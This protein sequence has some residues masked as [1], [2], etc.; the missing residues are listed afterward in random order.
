MSLGGVT[1][2]QVFGFGLCFFRGRGDAELDMLGVGFGFIG[3]ILRDKA[4]RTCVFGPGFGLCESILVD[5][6]G[7]VADKVGMR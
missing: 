4:G 6:T 7:G 5:K 3:L 2:P 1:E